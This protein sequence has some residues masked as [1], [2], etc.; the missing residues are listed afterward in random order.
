MAWDEPDL[1]QNVKRV[2][3]WLV[4][5]VSN[6]PAIHLSPFSPPRKK[7][8]LPQHSDYPFDGQIPLPP[9]THQL[10][11]S[12][13][14]FGCLPNTTPAGMQG[15]RHAQ[16]GLSLSNLHVNKQMQSGLFPVGFLPLDRG[17]TGPSSPL[18]PKPGSNENISCLLT[19]GNSTQGSNKH[20]DGKA[21]PF[22]LFGTPILPEKQISLSCSSDTVS[23]TRTGNSS[24]DGNGEK[25][26]NTSDGSG[27]DLNQN[28]AT[29][30]SSGEG[31]QP[32]LVETGHCKVFMESEDVGRTLDLSQLGSYEQLYRKLADM[33]GIEVSEMLN[34]VLYRDA[35]GRAK[36]VGDQPFR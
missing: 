19:M 9:F 25:M 13:N 17:P 26:V 14:P 21:A 4:E 31:I 10:V 24:S 5:L 6:M 7:M 16:Y 28:E 22:I 12:S 8:R 18:L 27:S 35:M 3:P 1:L 29:E 36:Q 32:E 2:S 23:P 33:F 34:R 15:A 11:G 30:R 20:S